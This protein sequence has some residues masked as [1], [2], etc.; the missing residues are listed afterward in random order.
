M[1][2]NLKL[3]LL[4]AAGL[5]TAT[6]AFGQAPVVPNVPQEDAYQLRALPPQEAQEEAET[7]VPN[8]YLETQFLKDRGIATY[9]WIDAGIGGNGWGSPFNGPITFNDRNWQGQMNQL[10]LVNE[11]GLDTADAGFDW[12]GRVDLLYGTDYIYTTA[13]GL[14]ANLYTQVLAGQPS[15]GNRYYGLAM[16]QLY[17]EAGYGD[18]A[19]KIGHF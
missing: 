10:Y 1:R 18:H 6:A 11:K 8:R 19:V 17:A 14:V 9:G 16:P 4:V 2:I 5:L 15:W 13:R 7:A 12:G 3:P